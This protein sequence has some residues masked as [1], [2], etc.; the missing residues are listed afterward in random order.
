MAEILAIPTP[1]LTR[2]ASNNHGVLDVEAMARQIDGRD[3][4]PA[5]GGE[6]P[7]FGP[8]FDTGTMAVFQLPSGQRLMTSVQIASVIVYLES[9]QRE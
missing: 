8:F 4:L 5:H 6:M 7:V 2:L 1:D 9:L 3:A